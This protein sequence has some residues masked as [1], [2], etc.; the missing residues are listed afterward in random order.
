MS[1]SIISQKFLIF[2]WVSKNSLSW[3]LG[4][5]NAHPQNTIKIGVSAHQFLKNSYASQNGHFWTKNQIQKFQL[6]FFLPTFFSFNNKKH[7]QIAENPI[8][9]VFSKP[10]KR[11]FS[12]FKLKTLKI[13]KPNFC[14]LFWSKR[15]IFRKMQK[16]GH[17][18][19]QNDNWAKTNRLKRLFL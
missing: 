12:K 7:K 8:F 6:S 17:K 11:E 14:T 1:F 13:E 5:E 3:Q 4:P 15:A 19:T 9:I 10:Q 2:W 18:K 16:I